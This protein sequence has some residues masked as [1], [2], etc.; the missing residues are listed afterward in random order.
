[1]PQEL[2]LHVGQGKSRQSLS[3]PECT[4]YGKH[5]FFSP[6]IR[7]QPVPRWQTS[8]MEE[9]YGSVRGHPWLVAKQNVSSGTHT[10]Q[11]Q[12]AVNKRDT[13]R[14]LVLS[15]QSQQPHKH[16][17]TKAHSSYL[18]AHSSFRKGQSQQGHAGLHLHG[19][20]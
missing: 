15:R 13:W 12:Q 20:S 9:G 19:C 18:F 10:A 17:Q 5:S 2:I 3:L 4:C 11:H 8:E 1:M 7:T 16:W 6:S 14:K